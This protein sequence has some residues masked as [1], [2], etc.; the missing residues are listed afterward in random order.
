VVLEGLVVILALA[1]VQEAALKEAVRDLQREMER[2]RLPGKTGGQLWLVAGAQG[3]VTHLRLLPV[4]CLA[5]EYLTL[6]RLSH[7]LSF[8]S[9]CHAVDMEYF[10]NVRLLPAAQPAARCPP[11]VA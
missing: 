3:P 5:P 11:A 1:C 8:A 10:K 7:F 9:S 2:Q 6:L 4:T